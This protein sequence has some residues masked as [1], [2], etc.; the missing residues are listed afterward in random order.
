VVGARVAVRDRLSRTILDP[1]EQV[2]C[3]QRII[4]PTT[5]KENEVWIFLI[6]NL[7]FLCDKYDMIVGII[8]TWKGHHDS[9]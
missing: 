6:P 3:P 5:W 1:L 4:W 7:Y 9:P 2:L 8:W